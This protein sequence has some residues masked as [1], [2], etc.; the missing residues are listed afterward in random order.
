MYPPTAPASLRDERF[1]QWWAAHDV[2]VRDTG[3]QHLRHPVGGDLPLDRNAVTWAADP[4]LQI[5]VRT[6]EP[7]TPCHDSLRPLAS[8]A[9]DPGHGISGS[10]V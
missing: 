1:R 6:A 3:A 2:A 8:W 9:A 4:D 10:S 5:I 7:G